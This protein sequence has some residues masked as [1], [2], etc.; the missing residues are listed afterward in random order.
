M[1]S[2]SSYQNQETLAQP[3]I[4][5]CIWSGTPRRWWQAATRSTTRQKLHQTSNTAAVSSRTRENKKYTNANQRINLLAHYWATCTSNLICKLRIDTGRHSRQHQYGARTQS[6]QY[7]KSILLQI[8]LNCN[9]ENVTSHGGKAS[10]L[11]D[12]THAVT[13]GE[14]NIYRYVSLTKKK[15][16]YTRRQE[17][18]NLTHH[19]VLHHITHR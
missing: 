8:W 10:K 3:L 14:T 1:R 9:A 15:S 12:T 16:G 4:Q 13:Q 19:P 7:K 5:T 18:L 11:L 17:L 6:G 2:I